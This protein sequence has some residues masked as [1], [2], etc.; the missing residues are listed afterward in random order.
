PRQRSDAVVA[1]SGGTVNIAG[2]SFS[3]AEAAEGSTSPAFAANDYE[4]QIRIYGTKFNYAFGPIS[5][6]S[7]TLSGTL[8]DG[9]PLEV[10]FRQMI[11]GEIILISAARPITSFAS[12]ATARGPIEDIFF[13][14]G[15]VHSIT[16]PVAGHVVISAGPEGPTTLKLPAGGSV[17]SDAKSSIAGLWVTNGGI[18]NVSGGTVSGCDANIFINPGVGNRGAAI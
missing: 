6:I 15:G 12:P 13:H 10:A 7:G 1:N 17:S 2:G 14:D 18:V 11:P 4:G 5:D 9:K 8:A 3:A 16:K